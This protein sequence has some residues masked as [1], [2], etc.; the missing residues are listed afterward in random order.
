M[1]DICF[2]AWD[3][4]EKEMVPHHK[5]V[6][7][8]DFWFSGLLIGDAP[9]GDALMQ[10]TGL[11]DKNGKDIYEGDIVEF[12]NIL[13]APTER[14]LIKAEIV[15][16]EERA[17]FMPQEMTENHKGGKYIHNW[18]CCLDLEIIGNVHQNE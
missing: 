18:D 4:S 15:F 3:D 6:L 5:L 10:F 12:T 1:R 2:R 11:Q 14:V 7:D 16:Y 9:E 8:P 13:H 17:Q